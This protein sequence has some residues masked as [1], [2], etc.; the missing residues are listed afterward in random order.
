[1][2]AKKHGVTGA[3]SAAKVRAEVARVTLELDGEPLAR[4]IRQLWKESGLG[5]KAFAKAMK[6]NKA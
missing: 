3:W 2:V 5:A 4:A 6:A 1:V